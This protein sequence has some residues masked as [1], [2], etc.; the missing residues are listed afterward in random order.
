MDLLIDFLKD[1][2]FGGVGSAISLAFAYLLWKLSE[3][4]YKG[5]SIK[6]IK[7]GKTVVEDLI[8]SCKAKELL[9]D[10]GSLR[11]YL[12]GVAS[13]FGWLQVDLLSEKAKDLGVF[14]LEGRTFVINLDNQPPAPEGGLRFSK[15]QIQ[16]MRELLTEMLK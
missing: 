9:D 13:P 16:Q 11:V 1:M 14:A 15:N 5:Y 7:A 6:V 4:K 8:G 10:R 12:K 2:A 3:R